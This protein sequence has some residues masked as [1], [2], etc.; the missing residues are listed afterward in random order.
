MKREILY[1]ELASI[2]GDAGNM[3]LFRQSCNDAVFRETGLEEEPWFVSED[4]D[5][6]YIGS[7]SEPKQLLVRDKLSQYK[8]RIR[9]L[10][11]KGTVFLVTGNAVELFG[12]YILDGNKKT[13]MLGIFDYQA[14]R[15]F[16][17]R[18]N[19][20]VLAQFEEIPIVAVKS[21]FSVIKGINENHFLKMEKGLGDSFNDEYEVI[22]YMNF[23]GTYCL[24]PLL[25]YNPLFTEH[26][27]TL[28]GQ[29]GNV[30]FRDELMETYQ[31]RLEKYR[32][33][34][35]PVELGHGFI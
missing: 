34:D 22:H 18:L 7:M 14:E 25:V 24:G 2:Y 4:V 5:F 26:L 16:D 19:Y 11:E 23:Y 10:I 28:C 13:E 35:S 6:I 8:G 31:E 17:K 33:P 29:K 3:M 21:Q 30:A 12:Q 27:L 20:I 1:P 9:E 15:S 32:K